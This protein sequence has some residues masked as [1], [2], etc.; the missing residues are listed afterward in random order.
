MSREQHLSVESNPQPNRLPRFSNDTSSSPENRCIKATEDG[1]PYIVGESYLINGE[2]WVYAGDFTEL[3]AA[4]VPNIRCCYIVGDCVYIRRFIKQTVPTK[5]TQ[6]RI[7]H[8]RADDDKPVNTAIGETDNILMRL[9]KT[10]LEKKNV[11]RGDY[12]NLYDTDSETNNS[13]RTIENGGNLSFPR[14]IDIV[15]RLGGSVDIKV[16]D[17]DGSVL[18]EVNNCNCNI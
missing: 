15:S 1:I 16:H 7:K 13:L 3:G 17:A 2:M 5:T 11:T 8:H 14:F 6:Q 10:T 9:G 18:C 12:R 4:K